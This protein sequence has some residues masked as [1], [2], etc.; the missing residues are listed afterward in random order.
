MFN[1]L[2]NLN[3]TIIFIKVKLLLNLIINIFDDHNIFEK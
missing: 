1:D 2:L 3:V